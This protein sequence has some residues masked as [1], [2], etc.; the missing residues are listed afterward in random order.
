VL[1]PGYLAGCDASLR[2]HAVF[3][4][5]VSCGARTDLDLAEVSV[6]DAASRSPVVDATLDAVISADGSGEA[7]TPVDARAPVDARFLLDA[8]S[9]LDAF[10][11]LDAANDSGVDAPT[12]AC[13]THAVVIDECGIPSC[14]KFEVMWTCGNQA[15]SVSG[16]CQS[17]AG[18]Y[19]G[20]CSVNGVPSSMF[21]AASA[22]LCNDAGAL[23]AF[24]ESLCEVSP[25]P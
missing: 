9:T 21:S 8:R 23:G 11:S 12:M 10:A 22:C 18:G 16:A 2:R 15:F 24:V 20:E 3:I 25:P 1:L 14:C 6:S 5:L 7:R 13:S 19:E 4:L 17:T